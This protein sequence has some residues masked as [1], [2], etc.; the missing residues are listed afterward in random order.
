MKLLA[1]WRYRLLMVFYLYITWDKSVWCIHKCKCIIETE[2]VFTFQTTVGCGLEQDCKNAAFCFSYCK[3]LKWFEADSPKIWLLFRFF[4]CWLSE[5]RVVAAYE[6]LVGVDVMR[7]L[8]FFSLCFNR[9][10]LSHLCLYI[11]APSKPF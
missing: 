3:Q 1:K 10:R 2:S 9:T 11:R 7:C 6:N 5:Q 4:F 8:S